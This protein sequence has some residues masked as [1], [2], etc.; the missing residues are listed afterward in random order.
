MKTQ[1]EKATAFRALHERDGA[2]IIPNPWEPARR[3][4]SR[5]GLRGPGHDQ[6]RLR[7]LARAARTT[8]SAATTMLE[9]VR[10][11]VSATDLPV[12]ADLENGFGDD[13]ETVAETIRL[14]AAT[15]LAGGSIEDSTGRPT[16]R[17]TGS[18][19]RSSGSAPRWR[20][21]APCPFPSR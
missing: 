15:G 4:C 2:F 9:H 3:G 21:R 8:R 5:S 13:P 6:R 19:W 12:S 7:V 17:S 14:A 20:R 11:I 18:S 16:I 1:T 10:A